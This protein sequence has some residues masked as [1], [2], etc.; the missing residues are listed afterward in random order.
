MSEVAFLSAAELLEKFRSKELSPVEAAEACLAQ[1]DKYDP[2][3]NAFCLVD[4]DRTL[5]QAR[6]SEQRWQSGE[7]AG[8]LDGVPAA[9]KDVFLTIGWPTLKGSKLSDPHQ[10][11]DVDAPAV[12]A[13]REAGA[14]F[15]GKT[16][17]PEFG[18]KGVTDSPLCG[19]TGNPWDPARTPG[20]SSGGSS[21]ALMLGMGTL[22]IGTDAGGSIRIPASFCGHPGI[23]PTLGRVPHW[24]P[25]PY[26]TLA[27]AGPMARNVDDLALLMDVLVRPDARDW[28]SLPPEKLRFRQ[29][30]D[31][32]VQ[33]LRIA[34]SPD[35]GRVQV[36]REVAKLV[37]AA[38]DVFADLGAHVEQQTPVFADPDRTYEVLWNS[39]AVRATLG[40]SKEQ[41]DQ[42]DP[43]L[44]RIAEQGR[45]Y[46]IEDYTQALRNQAELGVVMGLFHQHW[47]L[48]LTPT[49]PILAFEAGRD[50]PAGWGDARWQS[51]TPFTYPFNLTQQPAA[52]VPCGLT[53]SGLPVGLQIVGARHRDALVLQAAAA[54]ERARPFGRWPPMLDKDN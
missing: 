5:D 22:A 27:H 31:A 37:A 24:P 36:D 32:G 47:D 4:A 50:V 45:R 15:V 28:T 7:P 26:G 34:F 3:V 13:L 21:A 53:S 23:K 33:G 19:V 20:G 18:W 40:Y 11:W 42:L 35:L 46:S 6:R 14:V 10:A 17:T 9:V 38:A 30:I 44:K 52:S 2:A 1:I 16:T 8:L 39:G 48:L 29:S 51:W 12:T 49:V 41:M 43:G 25:P 54:Y